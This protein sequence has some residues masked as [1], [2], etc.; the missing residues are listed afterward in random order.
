MRQDPLQDLAKLALESGGSR[1][2]LVRMAIE[3]LKEAL[4]AS[5]VFFNRW[6]KETI[7]TNWGARIA[8]SKA[9][10]SV[11]T[12]LGAQA[13]EGPVEISFFGDSWDG[14]KEEA[15]RLISQIGSDDD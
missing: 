3:T 1:A 9:I 12:L 8:A 2:D 10:I 13:A 7:R 4:Q 5:D 11:E 6:G 14:F 15:H